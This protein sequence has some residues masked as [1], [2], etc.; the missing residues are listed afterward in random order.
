[1][2]ILFK[3]ISLCFVTI[4]PLLAATSTGTDFLQKSLKVKKP[5]R[6]Q[7]PGGE[8]HSFVLNYVTY[9]YILS[10]AVLHR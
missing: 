1:M 8:F 7:H 2:L 3:I 4:T 6:A 9:L 10:I 5:A